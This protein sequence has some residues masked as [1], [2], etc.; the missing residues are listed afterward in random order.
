MWPTN[1]TTAFTKINTIPRRGGEFAM[2]WHRSLIVLAIT[3]IE[4]QYPTISEKL[5]EP[6]FISKRS[7]YDLDYI[8]DLS[9]RT[10]Y[11][12][13]FTVCDEGGRQEPIRGDR[14]YIETG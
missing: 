10:R 1:H 4:G 2:C 7:Q 12:F 13:H 9:G 6:Q 11:I 3:Y 14:S 8:S 5:E